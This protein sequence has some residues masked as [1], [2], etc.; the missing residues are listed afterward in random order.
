MF[1]IRLQ[2]A[3]LDHRMTHAIGFN[4]AV[5]GAL[6]S[7]IDA[8]DAHRNRRR[9]A[10]ASASISFSSMSAFEIDVLDVVVLFERIEQLQQRR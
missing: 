7:T 2:H 5:S 9:L 4:D 8:E 3:G 6:G 1:R 10:Y